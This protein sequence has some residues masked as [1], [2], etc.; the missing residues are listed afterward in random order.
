MNK[1]EMMS[2]FC[3]ATETSLRIN[4]AKHLLACCSSDGGRHRAPATQT[5]IM[6]LAVDP[7]YSAISTAMGVM[8]ICGNLPHTDAA[9]M[10]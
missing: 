10:T 7:I 1:Q 2:G 3:Q 5:S 8:E 4:I 6:I 9:M